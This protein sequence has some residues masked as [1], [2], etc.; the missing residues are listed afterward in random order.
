M[1]VEII[2]IGDEILIGQ[3]VDSNSAWMAQKLNDIGANVARIVTISDT[4]DEILT[5]LSEAE[6]RADVVLITGGLGPTKDDVT[7]K[8]L[9]EFFDCDHTFHSEI[10]EHIARLFAGFGKEMSELNRLQAELPSACEPLQN[11]QGTA[12]GMWFE[13]NETVFV[14][15]PGVPYE[16]KGIMRD[17]V[18]PRLSKKFAAP[19]ILHRTILTMGM[20]ESWL[21]EIIEEW[22]EALPKEIKLAYLP[23][24]GR[25]RLRLSATGN[26]EDEL[27]ALLKDETVKL[28]KLIPKLIYGYDNDTIEGVVGKLLREAEKTVST[29]E[30]C[31][32]GLI[33]HKLTSISGSSDYF[34][35]SVVSYSNEVKMSALNVSEPDLKKHGAVSETVVRQMAEGIRSRMKTDYAIATSGI[36]G[37]TGGSEEKPVG[38]VWIAVATPEKTIAKKFLFGQNRSRNIEISANTALN[39]LRKEL[40]TAHT[41]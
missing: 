13:K 39:L 9:A 15:M 24:P 6:N 5:A 31:T 17:H 29:A 32:G 3:I 22:E 26:Q 37:P 16:M 27:K 23:S 28:Q 20:G 14:S 35:G 12:P 34:Q 4:Q 2:T 33:A 30:S 8:A 11:N 40:V 36:A 18:I 19:T 10:A 41:E 1:K 25:V 38:T 21:S 7:K